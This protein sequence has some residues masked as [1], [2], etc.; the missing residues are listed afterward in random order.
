MCIGIFIIRI[1]G[2]MALG[3]GSLLLALSRAVAAIRSFLGMSFVAGLLGFF[4]III[5][6]LLEVW[7]LWLYVSNL[8]TVVTSCLLGPVI[9]C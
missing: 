5:V 2:V 3:E 7:A 6:L 8:A 4:V 9:M 1:T